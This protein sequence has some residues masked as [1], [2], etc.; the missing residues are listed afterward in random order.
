MD[1]K[2]LSFSYSEGAFIQ[3]LNTAIEPGRVTTI[4]GPNGSGKSTLLNLIVKQLSPE[5]G[6]VL[7]NGKDITMCSYKQLAKQLAIVHQYNSAPPDLTVEKLVAYGRSPYQSFWS[8]K[9]EDDDEIIQ[10]A[11]QV[12]KLE[13]LAHKPVSK[14]SGG[15]RQ[16]TWIAMALAQKTDVLLLDEPTTY[17]DIY[18]QLEILAL[19]KELN[20]TYGIT[21]VM[22]LHD[23]NQAIQFSHNVIIMKQGSLLYAGPVESGITK[24]R[25]YEVY[26]IHASIG[27]SDENGCPYIVPILKKEEE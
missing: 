9:G 11:L 27:W 6:Q 23:I 5:G 10:W 8:S 15:E 16:R 20:E 14:L 19:V 13:K 26:G 12:T 1:I 4:I 2:N 22:V 24:E 3:N 18:Y 7:L 17:L 25:L 21:I